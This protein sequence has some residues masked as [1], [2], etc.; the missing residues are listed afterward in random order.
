MA[1]HMVEQQVVAWTRRHKNDKVVG[2][3]GCERNCPLV[4]F[5]M[6]TYGFQHVIVD[7]EMY[8][9]Y[10]SRYKKIITRDMPKW[11]GE[12]VN[13]VDNKVM[14]TPIT[15]GDFK[16]ILKKVGVEV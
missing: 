3:A 9:Y 7:E 6:E 13:K 14:S 1:H 5:L 16:N 4:H 10:S 12:V 2:K 11:A 8:E 15:M